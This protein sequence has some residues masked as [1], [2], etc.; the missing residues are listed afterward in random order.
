MRKRKK[1]K[2]VVETIILEKKNK[3]NSLKKSPLTLFRS[4]KI[5]DLY[6]RVSSNSVLTVK[7][8]EIPSLIYLYN[9]DIVK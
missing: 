7:G 4:P 1:V 5:C 2:Y 8:C 6:S 9:D 3:K